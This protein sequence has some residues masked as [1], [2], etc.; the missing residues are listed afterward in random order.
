MQNLRIVEVLRKARA[1][2]IGVAAFA[3][4]FPIEASACDFSLPSSSSLYK[5]ASAIFVG[6]VVESPWMRG[7]DGKTVVTPGRPAPVV[8]FSVKRRFRGADAAEITMPSIRSDCSYPFLQGETYLIH[9]FLYE[10][11]LEAGSPS[12]PL[13]LADAVEA[14]KYIE[15]ETNKR[16]QALLRAQVTL[17]KRDGTIA[18]IPSTG[19]PSIHLN[20]ASGRFQAKITSVQP[21]EIVVPPGE[22]RVWVEIGGKVVSE[23]KTVRLARGETLIRLGT[24]ML[25]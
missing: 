10:G 23:R 14:L 5:D 4:F 22:Y 9:A 19:N 3:V 21:C 11:A 7:A 8:R 24:N 20:G 6:T 2:W 18:A 1:L 25:D 16:P 12:R 15:G 17:L 13:L